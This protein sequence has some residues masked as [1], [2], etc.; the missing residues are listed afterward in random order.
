MIAARLLCGL[1]ACPLVLAADHPSA[2][3]GVPP[4]WAATAV[5][6]VVAR[7]QAPRLHW[8]P[9]SVTT[10]RW[11]WG[12]AKAGSCSLPDKVFHDGMEAQPFG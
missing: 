7:P 2:L 4:T 12:S 3:G 5:P 8:R 11:R 6:A 9:A 1:L 10:P